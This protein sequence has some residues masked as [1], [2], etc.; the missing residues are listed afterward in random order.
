MDRRSSTRLLLSSLALVALGG[1]VSGCVVRDQT[2]GYASDGVTYS[3]EPTYTAEVYVNAPPPA[4]VAEYPPVAPGPHFVW[5]NGYWDWSGYDWYWTSGYWVNPRRG[6]V[7][8]APRYLSHNGRWV[9]HRS[10][11]MDRHGSRDYRYAHP[12]APARGGWRNGPAA[13]QP[14]PA[15]P[16][17]PA[18]G[19][20]APA[21]GR[22]APAYGT[23]APAHPSGSQPAPPRWRNGA[24]NNAPPA[25]G[26]GWGQ[27]APAPAAPAVGH[28]SQPA[29]TATAPAAPTWRPGGAAA[30]MP[31][32]PPA[33]R[34][35]P[36]V[37]QPG[38]WTATPVR[39]GW[40][41]PAQPPAPPPASAGGGVSRGQPAA[42]APASGGGWSQPAQPSGSYGTPR[43]GAPAAGSGG[44]Q[45]QG[46]P[47]AP[48]QDQNRA[49]K[50]RPAAAES[51]R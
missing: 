35:A 30:P 48:I 36:A 31:A 45:P 27:A 11:W 1:G 5:I 25:S 9:Y 38:G 2:V 34:P 50:G 28:P 4:P 14:A 3:S 43:R 10:Y 12:A 18:Y 7:Y 32:P 44:G 6:Y 13:A 22:P 40:S 46:P 23:P 42:G 33:A 16:A 8:V 41:A 26:G 49:R 17:R 37:G 47:P 21:Y 15:Y 24:G 20:P 29:P 39:P 19:T 51:V